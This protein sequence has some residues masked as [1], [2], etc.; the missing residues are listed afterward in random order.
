MN[1]LIKGFPETVNHQARNLEKKTSSSRHFLRQVLT[2]VSELLLLRVGKHFKSVDILPVTRYS[3]GK[4]DLKIQ[5]KTEELHLSLD[6]L[7]VYFMPWF[8]APIAGLKLPKLYIYLLSRGESVKLA[9]TP[10]NT[11]EVNL[12]RRKC[13]LAPHI[14]RALTS[15]CKFCV[16]FTKSHTLNEIQCF[17]WERACTTACTEV[18]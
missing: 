7:V 12:H 2:H 5:T 18:R 6:F 8:L 3:S 15:I 1:N 14:L 17:L 9:R 16:Q 10:L 11:S 13:M 4:A